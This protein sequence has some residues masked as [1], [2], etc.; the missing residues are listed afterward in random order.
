MKR[1]SFSLILALSLGM[2][3]PA[4]A[5]TLSQY[6]VTSPQSSGNSLLLATKAN[7]G[8]FV[9]VDHPTQGQVNIIEDNGAKYLEISSNFKTDR[10]PNLRVILHNSSTV[11]PK[12]QPGE[13]L[14]LGELQAFQGSQRYQLPQN[15]DL[16]EY[17]SVAIWCEEFNVTF[18][19]ATLSQ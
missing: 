11:E 13:Y 14:N 2:S 18:G 17:Q 1:L 7:S 16:N 6:P 10:G 3:V 5:N 12:V 9:S 19:Y 8:N 15:L 4:N